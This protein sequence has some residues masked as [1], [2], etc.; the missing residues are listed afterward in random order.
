MMH[1]TTILFLLLLLAL[2]VLSWW[3]FARHQRKLRTRAWLMREAVRNR[4]FSFRLRTDGLSSGERAM[5]EAMND[6]SR[7]M[8]LMLA[9]NEAESWQ[10]LMRVLTHE[11]MN[12]ATPICSISHSFMSD[13]QFRGTIYEEGLRSIY[14][15]ATGLSAF[16]D[17]FRKVSCIQAPVMAEVNLLA[18]S[19]SMAT[20]YPDVSWHMDIPADLVLQADEQ[21][22][23]QMLGNLVRNAVEAGAADVDMRW[24]DA[25]YISN[26]GAGIPDDVA[27]EIFIPFFT[28]KR[29]GSG[30]GLALSRQM[31]LRQGMDILL[32]E[33][34]VAGYHTTFCIR[35][36]HDAKL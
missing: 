5:Q 19:R 11:I 33:R 22:L 20:S 36:R 30:I 14:Q 9:Q 25:M 8:G 6:I 23:R 12:A 16:V 18:L 28:T 29:N 15:T 24:A 21:M 2:L 13:P 7:E 35:P 31:L 1:H 26:N 32:A 17:N 27:R 4:D 3:L 34:P 10:R